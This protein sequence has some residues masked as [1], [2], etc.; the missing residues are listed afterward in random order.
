MSVDEMVVDSLQTPNILDERIRRMIKNEGTPETEISEKKQAGP[1]TA[2]EEEYESEGLVRVVHSQNEL[3]EIVEHQPH[4]TFVVEFAQY[5][6]RPCRYFERKFARLAERYSKHSVKFLKLYGDANDSTK[7]LFEEYRVTATPSFLIF[8]E[9]ELAKRTWGISEPKLV[10]KIETIINVE[11][12]K[13]PSMVG[14]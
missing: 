12:T 11:T 4:E 2:K 9:G 14:E 5:R 8:K 10:E 3:H 7:K 6:C 1:P 13:V